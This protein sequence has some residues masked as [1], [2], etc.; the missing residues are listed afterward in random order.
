M[1]SLA[2]DLADDEVISP[3]LVLVDPELAQLARQRLP[4]VPEWR[5]QR[6][7]PAAPAPP[8]LPVR[9]RVARKR[10]RIGVGA[11]VAATALLLLVPLVVPTMGGAL[12]QRPAAPAAPQKPPATP[13][14]DTGK[15]VSTRV[16]VEV[17]TLA[18]LQTA[19]ASS[20][21]PG[22]LDKKSGLLADNTNIVCSRVGRTS[23]FECRLRVGSSPGRTWLLTVAVTRDGAEKITWNEAVAVP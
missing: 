20:A 19:D 12:L 1:D 8:T 10:P 14:Q 6:L 5:P 22:A 4:D 7:P 17:R 15:W 3:E 11:L 18:L 21:P 23:V 13:A 16:E 9:R 2:R